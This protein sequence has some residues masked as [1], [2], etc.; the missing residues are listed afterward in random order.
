MT[1]PTCFFKMLFS[2]NIFIF[3]LK[4]TKFACFYATINIYFRHLPNPLARIISFQ[5]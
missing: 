2:L 3:A 1:S 4:V 5:S